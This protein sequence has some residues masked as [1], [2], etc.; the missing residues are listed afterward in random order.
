MDALH[1]A[2]NAGKKISFKYFDYNIRKRQIFRR[3][4]ETYTRSPVAMCWNEDNYYL[5]TYS[6][7]H[8][9]PFATYRVDRMAED[10]VLDESADE[11][12]SRKF[13]ISDY[14]KQTFGMYSGEVIKATL[15]FDEALVSVVL[16]HFGSDTRLTPAE[17]GRFTINAEVSNSPVFLGWM[18]QL[19]SK[20]E[21]LEPQSLRGAMLAQGDSVRAM[22]GK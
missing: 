9:D 18:F 3:H 22:Y 1:S 11:Y 4:G 5:V 17:N 6:P 14:V 8:D 20:A 7:K 12:D 19:G 2:I 16:D 15:A 13:K 21:I 10:T